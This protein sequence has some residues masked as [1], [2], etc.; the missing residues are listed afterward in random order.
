MNAAEDPS[1]HTMLV[2]KNLVEIIDIF[3]TCPATLA[4]DRN[5]SLQFT[6]ILERKPLVRVPEEFTR[7]DELI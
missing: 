3:Q 1:D 6:Q 5:R 4:K 2:Y 7:A